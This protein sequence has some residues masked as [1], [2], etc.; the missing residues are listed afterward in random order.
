MQGTVGGARGGRGPAFNSGLFMAVVV[1]FC[2]LS[3]SGG[4]Q[5]EDDRKR[6]SLES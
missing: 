1:I 2:Q 3:V 4:G 6:L 5:E